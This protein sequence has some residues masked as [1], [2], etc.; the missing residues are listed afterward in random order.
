MSRVLL[1]PSHVGR[2][3]GAVGEELTCVGVAP[4]PPPG[5]AAAAA[6]VGRLRRELT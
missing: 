2:V 6:A 3:G 5:A 1:S 4:A